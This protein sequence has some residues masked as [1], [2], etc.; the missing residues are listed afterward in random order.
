MF[1]IGNKN[2]FENVKKW[3]HEVDQKANHSI[4][5]ILIGNKLDI[6]ESGKG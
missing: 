6:I 5:K 1:D 3:N 2:S 4:S